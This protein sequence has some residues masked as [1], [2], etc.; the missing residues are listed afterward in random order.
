M[1]TPVSYAAAARS[2]TRIFEG[3]QVYSQASN[4][5]GRPRS[6]SPHQTPQTE[7]EEEHV[8]ILTFL[9]D[10]SHHDRMTE[11]RNKYFPKHLNKLSAH[12]TIFHALPGSRMESSVIPTIEE[13][14]SKTARFPV[15]ARQPFRLGKRGIAIAVPEGEGGKQAK[16]IRHDLQQSWKRIRILSQQDAQKTGS[17]FPHYTIMNKVDDEAEVKRVEEE[18]RRDFVADRGVVEGLGLYLYDKGRWRW[19]KRFDFGNAVE[20]EKT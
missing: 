19:V 14:T 2:S 8:Y 11:L 12:L 15:T 1:S 4:E 6:R 9:T 18:L 3:G 13:V 10:Q 16:Q 7:A 20:D 5:N 17:T